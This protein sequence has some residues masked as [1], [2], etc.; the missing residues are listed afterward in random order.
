MLGEPNAFC[1]VLG[2]FWLYRRSRMTVGEFLAARRRFAQKE[3]LPRLVFA[4]ARALLPVLLSLHG[5]SSS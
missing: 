3:P 5:R 4:G 2:A 1:E